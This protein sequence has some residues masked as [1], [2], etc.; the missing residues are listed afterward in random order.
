MDSNKAFEIL[1]SS[2]LQAGSNFLIADGEVFEVL[3][4]YYGGIASRRHVKPGEED[5]GFWYEEAVNDPH[6]LYHKRSS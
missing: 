3:V 4:W 2:N 5:F 6:T 1:E